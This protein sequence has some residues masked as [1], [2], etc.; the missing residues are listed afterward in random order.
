MGQ[1]A[2][3]LKE[4]NKKSTTI[5][6]PPPLPPFPANAF[7]SPERP[8]PYPPTSSASTAAAAARF[9][10]RRRPAQKS[11]S[12]LPSPIAPSPPPSSPSPPRPVL[13]VSAPQAPFPFSMLVLVLLGTMPSH[14]GHSVSSCRG[15][16]EGLPLPLHARFPN[17][18]GNPAAILFC[19]W[20]GERADGDE[21]Q[22]VRCNINIHPVAAY[23][24][25]CADSSI[26]RVESREKINNIIKLIKIN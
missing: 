17:L 20:G 19:G 12:Q 16:R 24:R 5:V 18:V 1:A 21:T 11:L 8:P 23:P 25:V 13:T 26:L 10:D 7:F 9:R 15:A 4:K 3:N 2:N 6:P 22:T 14:Y